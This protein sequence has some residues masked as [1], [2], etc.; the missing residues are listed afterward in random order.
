MRATAQSCSHGSSDVPRENRPF[1]HNLLLSS[2]L[3]AAGMPLK[4]KQFPSR[5]WRLQPRLKPRG[6]VI[7]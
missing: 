1:L 6:R 4:D 2:S 3:L 7:T 5:G